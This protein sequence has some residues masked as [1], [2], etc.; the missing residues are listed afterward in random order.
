MFQYPTSGFSLFYVQQL[1]S[2]Q[3]SISV[4]MPYFGLFSFLPIS[5]NTIIK[6]FKT[7][8]MP[9]LG[10]SSFLHICSKLVTHYL[11]RRFNAL[12]RAFFF[13]TATYR[14]RNV[15]SILCFNA[16]PRAFFFSTIF[17]MLHRQKNS[18]L[19]QCPTSGFLLF[20]P[21]NACSISIQ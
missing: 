13:S 8:S 17:T 3:S 14:L 5:M 11:I 12:P 16:L 20:Y 1:T 19:F 6:F 10:L 7:V 2:C 4:S 15:R 9:Y 18:R 21:G